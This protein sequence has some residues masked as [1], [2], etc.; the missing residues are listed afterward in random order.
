MQAAPDVTRARDA[1]MPQRR[2][3]FRCDLQRAQIILDR[4][5]SQQS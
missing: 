4:L 5:G 3:M 2:Q 1:E